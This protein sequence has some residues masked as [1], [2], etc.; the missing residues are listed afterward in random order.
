MHSTIVLLLNTEAN[1]PNSISLFFADTSPKEFLFIMAFVIPCV[2][3]IVCYAR[4][5]Y[6]V[7]KTALRSH[8]ISGSTLG[9][10]MHCQTGRTQ[11]NN[12]CKKLYAANNMKNGSDGTDVHLLPKSEDVSGESGRNE[13][14]EHTTITE[15]N[16]KK[17]YIGKNFLDCDNSSALLTHSQSHG[18]IKS[19]MKFIDGTIENDYPSATLRKSHGHE[20]VANKLTAN[21]RN[22]SNVSISRTVE[23]IEANGDRHNSCDRDFIVKMTQ[24]NNVDS[25]IEESISSIENNQVRPFEL[26]SFIFF[27]VFYACIH[28]CI[29]YMTKLT[30]NLMYFRC[31]TSKATTIA[32]K[33]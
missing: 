32:C 27:I 5:F 8:D 15:S 21:D 33:F 10:S 22:L 13:R 18:D 29:S 26:F 11:N 7:R 9:N 6:I 23:F 14:S 2:S 20:V 25:A 3:I 28:A 30:L 19:A 17:H 16:G 12:Q 24:D 31:I 4:I 1:E